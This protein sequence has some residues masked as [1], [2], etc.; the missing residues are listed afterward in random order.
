MRSFGLVGVCLALLSAAACDGSASLDTGVD[1]EPQDD[2]GIVDHDADVPLDA[3]HLVVDAAPPDAGS[4]DAAS[5]CD[6]VDCDDPACARAGYDCVGSAPPGWHG[7]IALFDRA[8]A[9]FEGCPEGF[10]DI[11]FMAHAGLVAPPA[12]CSE[13]ACSAPTGGSCVLE[14]EL[15]VRDAAC[16][17]APSCVAPMP[18]P[19]GWTG[20]CRFAAAVPGG[21][22]GCGP[23]SLTCSGSSGGACNKAVTAPA[24]TAIGGSCAPSPQV[25]TREPHQWTRFAVGCRAPTDAR[26]CGAGATCARADDA[27]P[28]CIYM[29]GDVACPAGPYA[30]RRTFHT[31]V[32]D[33]RGCSECACDPAEG[34]RCT[35]AVTVYSDRAAMCSTPVATVPAGGCADL[36]GNPTIGAHAASLTLASPGSCTPSGGAPIGSVTPGGSFTVCCLPAG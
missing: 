1:A 9:A 28:M 16:T 8:P 7:P 12:T 24:P 35:G 30:E 25:A 27:L 2:A 33:T 3:G 31:D 29:E 32:I 5:S 11:A 10:D 23:G 6:V 17:E 21:Q 36:T 4:P 14:G 13:C 20:T 26:G 15:V 22:L 18:L 19:S 34:A